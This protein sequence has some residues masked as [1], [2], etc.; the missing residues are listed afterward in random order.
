[1]YHAES[2][3]DVQQFVRDR[4][5]VVATGAGTKSALS[6]HANLGVGKLSGVLQYQPSEYTFTALAGTP[7]RAVQQ[8]LA[9]NR[10]YLPFDPPLVDS[11]ATLG[12]TVAAGLSGPGRFRYG[13][14]RDF[15]LGVRLVNG[16]GDVVYGGGKVVKNAAGFDFPKLMIG[17]LGQFGVLV[18]FTFKVFPAREASSTICVRLAD[19][20]ESVD[21]MNCLA[22]SNA[23]IDHLDYEPPQHLRIRIS[24]MRDALA[25]RI[26]RLRD[27]FPAT[28]SV[29]H[30]GEDSWA[31]VREF[32]W[33]PVGHGV[34]KIPLAP[35]DILKVEQFIATLDTSIPRRYS[36]GGNVAWLGW[37]E[38]LSESH[39]VEMLTA[40]DR[41]ALAV[42]G[43]W[44][45]PLFGAVRGQAFAE[46]LRT[47]FDPS[48]KF[49]VDVTAGG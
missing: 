46:R 49:C 39:L 25:G 28:A 43:R 48:G 20:A 5:H 32:G 11:G 9:A 33:V 23:E 34:L 19:A 47:V 4:S 31:D 13:G 24:G 2:I 35:L 7:V 30:V 42:T 14:V 22:A 8:Q 37:P 26:D 36:G 45:R 12:G 27:F 40:I 21:S 38:G 10:Q 17:G 6:R 3:S 41:P 16:L 44:S 29:E 1:M 15:L 18:E